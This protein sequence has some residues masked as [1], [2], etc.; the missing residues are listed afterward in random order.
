MRV[1]A[2]VLLLGHSLIASQVPEHRGPCRVESYVLSNGLSV[3]LCPDPTIDTVSVVVTYGVGAANDPPGQSGIAHFLEL[4]AI[5]DDSGLVPNAQI[6]EVVAARGT[7]DSPVWYGHTDFLNT[8]PPSHLERVLWWESERMRP[9][10]Q[11]VAG[12]TFERVRQSAWL[13]TARTHSQPWSTPSAALRRAAYAAPHPYREFVLGKLEELLR[14]SESD[15]RKFR[16]RAYAPSNAFLTLV[17]A[18]DAG[19]VR[20]MVERYFA[21][22]SRQPRLEPPSIPV[23]LLKEDIRLRVESRLTTDTIYLLWP[24]VGARH[25]DAPALKV[26]ASL[27]RQLSVPLS[28]RAGEH[29]AGELLVEMARPVGKTAA[30]VEL[31]VERIRAGLSGPELQEEAFALAREA[32][33]RAE[34]TELAK[35]AVRASRLSLAWMIFGEPSRAFREPDILRRVSAEDVR[36][37][38]ARY[39]TGRRVVV[40]A[41]ASSDTPIP[42]LSRRQRSDDGILGIWRGVVTDGKAKYDVEV[43]VDDLKVGAP[44]AKTRYFNGRNCAGTLALMEQSSDGSYVFAE[45]IDAGR[46]CPGGRVSLRREAGQLK[47]E[48]RSRLLAPAWSIPPATADLHR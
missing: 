7:F 1:A 5:A 13:Q 4:L 48:W 33:A 12:L 43:L 3:T 16:Q 46:G 28:Y 25:R 40:E 22:I 15:V 36:R 21:N 41:I 32:A 24:A 47:Y 2:V 19:H 8:V 17:G 23:R 35:P 42:P 27:F 11:P 26:L 44:G 29:D 6:L 9:L 45:T 38:A 14:V 34:E 20:Q 37:V 30:D 18:F 10:V 39:L 31:E